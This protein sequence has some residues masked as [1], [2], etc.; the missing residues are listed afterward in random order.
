MT[1]DPAER[2]RHEPGPGGCGC[3]ASSLAPHTAPTRREQ[4]QL[5]DA[6]GPVQ[7]EEVGSGPNTIKNCKMVTAEQ[8]AQR[9]ALLSMGAGESAG[10]SPGLSPGLPHPKISKPRKT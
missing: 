6:Q 5:H 7:N 1:G 9:G 4:G 8:H 3:H 10:L 2:A